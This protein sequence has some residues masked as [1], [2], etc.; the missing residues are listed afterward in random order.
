[1][2]DGELIERAA[3]GDRAAFVT[4]VERHRGMVYRVA[5]QYAGN[6]YDADDIAQDV[7]IKVHR[8]L[9]AFRRDAQFTSW[10]YRITMNACID[11]GRR[12][13]PTTSL[14]GASPDDRVSEV[15][16]EDPGPDQRVF[17]GEVRREVEQAV[18]SLPPQQRIVFTMRHFEG[19]KLCEIAES[20]GVAEGTVKRQLHSAVHRLRHALRHVRGI[21][22]APDTRRLP[23]IA[24]S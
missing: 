6:H 20:L 4:L 10:L 3:E 5:F 18:D 19:M 7:F 21:A 17:A 11:H 24:N 14:D 22:T 2:D 8:S 16:A 15:V 1:M 23:G 12:R 9:P 13:S